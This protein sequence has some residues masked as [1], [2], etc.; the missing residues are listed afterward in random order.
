MSRAELVRLFLSPEW[1][2]ELAQS[3]LQRAYVECKDPELRLGILSVLSLLDELLAGLGDSVGSTHHG[4][5][6]PEEGSPPGGP[7]VNEDQLVLFEGE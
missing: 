1:N 6:S 5:A 7:D 3:Y 4:G 2:L